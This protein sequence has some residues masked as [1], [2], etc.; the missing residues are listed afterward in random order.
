[1][2]TVLGLFGT[3]Q[4]EAN[5]RPKNYRE[6]IL[7]TSPNGTAPIT[8]LTS[9]MRS[10]RVDDPH[11]F[12]Y[13]MTYATRHLTVNG[14]VLVGGTALVVDSGAK[15]CPVGTVL[16]IPVTGEQVKVT[17]NAGNDTGLTISRA[18]AGTTAVAIPDNAQISVMSNAWAEGTNSPTAVARTPVRRES[19]TQIFKQSVEHTRTMSRTRTRTQDQIKL[20][21]RM[22]RDFHMED[23]EK[24]FFWGVA[25]ETVEAASGQY[26]RTTA[27]AQSIITTNV[28]DY[29]N[30]GSM[31]KLDTFFKNLFKYGVEM[32]RT[33][34]GGNDFIQRLNMLIR[35]ESD[36]VIDQEKIT[37]Y[38]MD[39]KRLIT[40][41]G[42]VAF[43]RHPLL[44]A[45]PYY[46]NS[47]WFFSMSNIEYVYLDDTMFLP[48]V[49]AN[50]FDGKKDMFLTECGFLI[51][52]EET[53]GIIYNL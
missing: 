27:G 19:Y 7:F 25:S 17:A 47:A 46:A 12:W 28:K 52:L 14:A 43:R 3:G 29:E 24:T 44:N 38:G 22:A 18:W 10:R 42:D 40:P 11:Y 13:D 32:T 41:Y 45:D 16:R 31:T 49:Q 1:M 8:A 33:C 23:I 4:F 37:E 5:Q 30:K 39:F 35:G 26:I 6:Q 51:G 2:A 36:Y 48:N 53:H 21:I 15:F 50:D 9:K 34:F 20:D